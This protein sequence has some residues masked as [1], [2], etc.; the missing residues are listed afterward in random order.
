ML[1]ILCHFHGLLFRTEMLDKLICRHPEQYA[2]LATRCS[3]VLIAC[4]FTA[5][6]IYHSSR[7]GYEAKCIQFVR[8]AGYSA[9]WI[10]FVN[11]GR[12]IGSNP[13]GWTK[14]SD[15]LLINYR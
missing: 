15:Q 3:L 14:A 12:L 8:Q 1:S 6:A 2:A 11:T 5:L 9:R 4:H 13:V 7:G 10:G